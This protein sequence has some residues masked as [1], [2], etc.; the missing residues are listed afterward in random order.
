MPSWFSPYC[1]SAAPRSRAALGDAATVSDSPAAGSVVLAHAGAAAAPIWAPGRR[2]SRASSRAAHDLQ[3][4]VERVTG[5]R[6]SF[7]TD[8]PAAGPDAVILGTLGRSAR[9]STASL[10]AAG[11]DAGADPR[12]KWEVLPHPRSWTTRS[13]AWP[14]PLSSPA[15]DKRGT[16]YGIY[17]EVSDDRSA[18]RRGTGGGTSR[19]AAATSLYVPPIRRS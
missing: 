8:K 6:P 2:S 10:R 1:S 13:P 12:A 15:C 4:D 3:S 16:I 7:S 9:S 11:V 14:G 19:R 18:S 5:L 17:A